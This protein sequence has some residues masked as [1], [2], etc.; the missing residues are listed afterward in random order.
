[1]NN[2]MSFI[3]QTELDQY[4]Q[5]NQTNLEQANTDY[6]IQNSRVDTNKPSGLGQRI[7]N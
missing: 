6:I 1:M 3:N 2:N 7:I 5:Q 4:L